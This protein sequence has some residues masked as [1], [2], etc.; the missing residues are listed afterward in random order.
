M[1]RRVAGS[2][3]FPGGLTRHFAKRS[4]AVF[5]QRLKAALKS[6]RRNFMGFSVEVVAAQ[7]GVAEAAEV[8]VV[9]ELASA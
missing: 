7:V 8:P 9:V 5:G 3:R 1:N 2:G 4:A 6:I